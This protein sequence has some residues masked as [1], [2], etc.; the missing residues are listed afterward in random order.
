MMGS[1]WLVWPDL[2]KF[3]GL[4]Q[5]RLQSQTKRDTITTFFLFY[6]HLVSSTSFNPVSLLILHLH[7]LSSPIH[8]SKMLAFR[9]L[10]R[11]APRALPR[12]PRA[13]SSLLARLPAA[14]ATAVRASLPR[15]TYSFSTSAFRAAQSSGEV[16]AELSAKLESEIQFEEEVSMEE[17]MPA[18]IKDFLATGQ[19]ELVDI[20]GKEEV[21]LVRNHGDEK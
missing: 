2:W 8:N 5:A 7:S 3:F 17:Q 10:G 12:L 9:S 21:K 1:V 18:S 13:S 14:R 6:Q 15:S 16:D 20:E 4:L 19:F 11:A